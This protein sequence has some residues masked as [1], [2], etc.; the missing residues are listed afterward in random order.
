MVNCGIS[1][2]RLDDSSA[3]VETYSVDPPPSGY[4]PYNSSCWGLFYFHDEASLSTVDPVTIG[5][6]EIDDG[7]TETLL[8]SENL[9]ATN[10]A[11]RTDGG[12]IRQSDV[13]FVWWAKGIQTQDAGA[14]P[15]ITD[16]DTFKT[17][18]ENGDASI[19]SLSSSGRFAARPSSHHP[20]GAN[21]VFADGH[22]DFIS[23]RVDYEVYRD[24]MIPSQTDAW[25]LI[26]P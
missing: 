19:N 1:D 16:F 26:V 4:D 25:R 17:A 18:V 3:D 23:E 12:R 21:V 9:Q 6:D 14:A 7:A 10:W 24:Q 5:L 15:S 2:F 13:G 20:L 22:S 11:S 8:L